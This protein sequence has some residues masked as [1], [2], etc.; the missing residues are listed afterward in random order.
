MFGDHE[1]CFHN[2][3]IVIDYEKR[4]VFYITQS[5]FVNISKETCWS[6]YSGLNVGLFY[7]Y[8]ILIKCF[9]SAWFIIFY[10]VWRVSGYYVSIHNFIVQYWNNKWFSVLAICF[11]YSI[12]IQM[13]DVCH[14]FIVAHIMKLKHKYNSI[15]AYVIMPCIIR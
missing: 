1:K 8:L 10:P 6:T 13:I 12:C 15:V 7:R 5:D 4:Q 11:S 3:I 2:K 9:V 14:F